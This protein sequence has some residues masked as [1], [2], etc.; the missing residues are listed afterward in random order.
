MPA[1]PNGSNKVTGYNVTLE[2][3]GGGGGGS[4]GN[5]YNGGSATITFTVDGTNYTI[6]AGG[7][8]GGSSAS[9][10]AGGGAAGTVSIPTALVNDP[11]FTFQQFGANAG[12]SGSGQSPDAVSKRD[13]MEKVEM[14]VVRSTQ[15]TGNQHKVIIAMVLSILIVSYLQV[16]L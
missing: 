7:G 6:T 12:T 1:Q 2:G 13:K 9:G 5:A 16:V 11:R 3:C 4:F 14:V 10:G 15:T 8:S